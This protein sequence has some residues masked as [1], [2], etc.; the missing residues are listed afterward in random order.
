[1]NQFFIN[2]T[3]KLDLELYKNSTLA[4]VDSITFK[5]IREY[6]PDISYGNFD[7]TGVSLEDLKKE[8]LNLNV[9]KY[10]TNG[11]SPKAKR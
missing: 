8:I 10:S 4:D 1:M 2:I 9:K 7:F 5:K 3:K 6:F 11:S